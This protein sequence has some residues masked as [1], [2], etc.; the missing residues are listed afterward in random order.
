MID[1]RK[2]TVALDVEEILKNVY[3][4]S[5]CIAWMSGGEDRPEIFTSDN[6]N[7][8][9]LYGRNAFLSL[10]GAIAP[11][12][13]SEAFSV[14]E[15]WEKLELPLLLPGGSPCSGGRLRRLAEAFVAKSVLAECYAARPQLASKFGR[16]RDGCLSAIR[17]AV[18]GTDLRRSCTL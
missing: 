8:L 9:A 12:V 6:R 5:A 3:A 15:D 7:L 16:E 13:D 10:A 18:A 2:L 11:L 14:P 1:T 4:E 17:L